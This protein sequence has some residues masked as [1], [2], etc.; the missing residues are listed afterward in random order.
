MDAYSI[1]GS[2]TYEAQAVQRWLNG[3]YFGR[4]DYFI[5]P[6]DGL[7][8]RDVQRGLM[9]AIQ[10]EL[11]MA[12]GTANGNFGPGT[13]SGL[14]TYGAFGLGATDS[15]RRLVRLFKAALI[16]NGYIVPFNGTF[17][18]TTSAQTSAFQSF[19]GLAATGSANFQTW[20]SLLVSTGDPNR[21]VTGADASTPLTAGKATALYLAGYRSIGRYLTVESKR[22]Q[23]GELAV[24]F[25]G[26]LSTFPIYQEYN[27]TVGAFSYSSG[28]AQGIAAV[29]RARQLGFKAGT[30]IHFAV[31][32]DATG[33]EISAAIVPFFEGVRD[34]H[35]RRGWDIRSASMGHATSARASAAP[36]W[37]SARSSR[38]CRRATAETSDSPFR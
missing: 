16:F 25:G 9:L 18:S 32:Y 38:E 5:M 24:I 6:C 11:G 4:A 34:A 35:R 20:A 10:Y 31:D 21:S 2:G 13:Q 27:N 8:S 22:Y 7:Y 14:Q 37:Q 12:D 3:T 19:V 28:R 29:R 33:D 1:L 15:T 26:G 36:V 30:V 23:P 17:D